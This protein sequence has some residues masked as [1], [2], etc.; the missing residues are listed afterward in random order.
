[1]T[2]CRSCGQTLETTMMDLG[3]MP[4]ANSFPRPDETHEEPLFPLH[5]MVCHGCLMVQLR[6][7]IPPE[8]LFSH[9]SYLSSTSDSWVVEARRFAES[10]TASLPLKASDLVLEIASNDGYLLKHFKA[11]GIRVLGVDPAENIAALASAAG[12][13]TEVRFFDSKAAEDLLSD[14][15][16]AN[17][18]VANNVIAHVPDINDFVE[19]VRRVLSPRGTFSFEFQHLLNLLKL[20]QFDTIYH[21]HCSY[22]SMHVLEGILARHDLRIIDVVELATHGGSLRVIGGH[23][24][25]ERSEKE[26]VEQIRTDERE[27]GLLDL[28]VYR[29]FQKHA[30]LA[31][32][33]LRDVLYEARQGGDRIGAY[34]AA[35]KGTILL[36]FCS[37]GPDDIPYVVDR[38]PLKQGRLIPGVHIPIAGVQE[39]ARQKPTLLIVLPWNLKEEILQQMS[40]IR[41]WG[42][43]FLIPLPEPHEA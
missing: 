42:G 31:R 36:N 5:A 25:D 6:D 39:I 27:A 22:L 37:W 13:P 15:G 29:G 35:A 9:Y 32:D 19:G 41:S 10:S 12:I 43:R 40:G 21:E 26:A 30:E 4:L 16:Q 17:L 2:A 23:A 38:N 3:L 7:L 34:G 24:A 18:V 8:Q 33:R 14:A 28:N 20:G 1:M 11:L